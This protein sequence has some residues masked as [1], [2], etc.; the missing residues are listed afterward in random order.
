MIVESPP[1]T[2][3]KILESDIPYASE[4]ERMGMVREPVEIFAPRSRAAACYSS[5]WREI[6]QQVGD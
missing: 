5:L 1:K 2:K 4:V 3:T 6:Q